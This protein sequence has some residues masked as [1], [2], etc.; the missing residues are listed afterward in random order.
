MDPKPTTPDPTPISARAVHS[1]PR[2]VVTAPVLMWLHFAALPCILGAVVMLFLFRMTDVES[3]PITEEEA[4]AM[5]FF[6]AGA[7]LIPAVV[8][9]LVGILAVNLLRGRRWAW[10]ATLVFN[11]VWIALG[12]LSFFGTAPI[13]SPLLIGFEGAIAA[14]LSTPSAKAWFTNPPNAGPLIVAWPKDKD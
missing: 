13:P 8:L 2:S 10:T 6:G 14:C 1:A 12:L 5:L 7:M 3:G 9:T 4:T 11:G